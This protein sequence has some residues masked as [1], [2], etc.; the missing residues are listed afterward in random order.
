[1]DDAT[2][3]AQLKEKASIQAEPFRSAVQWMP[4]D[5][6]I[7]YNSM[8]YWEPVPWDNHSGRVTLAGDAV[9]PMPPR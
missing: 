1:L 9:H 2:R 4:E 6:E 5:T 8:A 7:T 3:L